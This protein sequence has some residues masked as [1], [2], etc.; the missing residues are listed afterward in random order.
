[1]DEVFKAYNGGVEV[2]NTV[3]TPEEQAARANWEQILATHSGDAMNIKEGAGDEYM[4]SSESADVTK[5]SLYVLAN[6][7]LKSQELK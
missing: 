7:S 5:F 1:M 2:D 4:T 6:G 3:I